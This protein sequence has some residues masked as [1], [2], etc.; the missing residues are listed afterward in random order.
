MRPLPVA[1][2]ALLAAGASPQSAPQ[3][4]GKSVRGTIDGLPFL[5]LR[6]THR[7]RGRD[8][9]YLCA[10]EIVQVIDAF[11]PVVGLRKPGGW[12]RDY[13]PAARKFAWP[14]RYEEELAG[15]L[16]GIRKALPGREARTLKSAG[17]EISVDDLKVMNSV[18]D[19]FGMGCSSFSAWGALT[20]DG[21]TVTGRNTDYVTFPIPLLGCVIGTEPAEE[22]LRPTLG[23][24]FMG[25]LSSGTV[26]NSEGAFLAL[27]DSGTLPRDGSRPYVPR[28]MSL[29]SAIEGAS[30]ARAVEDVAAALRKAPVLVGNNIHV[31]APG[32]AA[33]VLEWDSNGKDR[34]VTVRAPKADEFAAGLVCT[35]HYRARAGP[36]DCGRYSKLGAALLRLQ[37]DGR[38][39][40][41]ATAQKML[42]SV[43]VN[44][45]SVTYL[46]VVVTP[47][48]RRMAIAYSPERGVS[49]TRG[50]WVTVDWERIFVQ[51]R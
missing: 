10:R 34:G 24:S 36:S 37:A 1:L 43:A 8:H 49:A 17:R 22:G 32:G 16:E 42:D 9:G 47:K 39:L 18:S 2:A 35:N 40:D 38:A 31:S 50:R 44:G 11:I 28:M 25:M 23:A 30:G 6:G 12:D 5:L 14:A 46:S 48:A 41:L 13:V 51:A 27:H 26:M 21:E 33:A 15:M 3:S 4:H 29:Q 19:I 7:E 20:P 45:A